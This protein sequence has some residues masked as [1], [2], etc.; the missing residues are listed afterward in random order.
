[1]YML[2]VSVENLVCTRPQEPR[3]LW[4]YRILKHQR[5]DLVAGSVVRDNVC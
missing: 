4:L 3:R 5:F 2:Y 1:M